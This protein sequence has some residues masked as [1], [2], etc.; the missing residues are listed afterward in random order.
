MIELLNWYPTTFVNSL[1]LIWRST[2]CRW[3]YC[4][5]IFR[6]VVGTWHWNG[7]CA[8]EL[9][10]NSVSYSWTWPGRRFPKQHLPWKQAILSLEHVYTMFVWLNDRWMHWS[11]FWHAHLC[12]VTKQW[13]VGLN[14]QWDSK[15]VAPS[16]TGANVFVAPVYYREWHDVAPN[17]T[18]TSPTWLRSITL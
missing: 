4:Y 14:E 16:L 13:Q 17:L 1:Q 11:T 18:T 15:V 8:I 9:L 7:T 5:H 12:D 3:I 2:T 6:Q 10:C